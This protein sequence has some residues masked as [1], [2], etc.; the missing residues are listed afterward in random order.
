MYKDKDK[1]READRQRQKRRRDKIKGK[2]VTSQGV[3][4]SVTKRGKDIKVFAGLPLDVQQTIDRLSESNEEKM[5]RTANAIHYQHVFP[6]RYH[7]SSDIRFT[8]LMAGYVPPGR[9][10]T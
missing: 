3:T 7:P 9:G 2:G 5:R 4:E 1:Q 10:P 8:T 6:D